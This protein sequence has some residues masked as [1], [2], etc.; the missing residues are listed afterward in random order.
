MENIAMIL[1]FHSLAVMKFVICQIYC[2]GMKK[3]NPVTHNCPFFSKVGLKVIISRFHEKNK[4]KQL[5]HHRIR[6]IAR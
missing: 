5:N 1:C 4:V 3:I 2:A 6:F